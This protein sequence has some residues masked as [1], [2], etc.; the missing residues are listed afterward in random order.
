MSD[1]KKYDPENVESTL[2]EIQNRDAE[3]PHIEGHA[4]RQMWIKRVI[5]CCRADDFRQLIGQQL[6]MYCDYPSLSEL[7]N[8]CDTPK[9][10]V[11]NNLMVFEIDHPQFVGPCKKCIFW[12]RK[13]WC[14]RNAARTEPDK[15]CSAFIARL[16]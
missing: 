4:F 9:H 5:Q 11:R 14:S 10:R 16:G 13:S 12:N 7:L 6:A 8:A 3:H 1:Y 15:E 2:V